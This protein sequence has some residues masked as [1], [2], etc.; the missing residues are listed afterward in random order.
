MTNAAVELSNGNK[1]EDGIQMGCGN[2]RRLNRF[3]EVE[4]L[5]AKEPTSGTDGAQA[6]ETPAPASVSTL[7]PVDNAPVINKDASAADNGDVKAGT[8][9]RIFGIR[10][11]WV[12][13]GT[14]LL[15]SAIYFGY[16]YFKNKKKPATIPAE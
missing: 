13:L 8:Q 4:K 12:V 15:A 1:I 6:S 10:L 5:T 14:V 16:R 9:I 11:I 3:R 7:L 2:M